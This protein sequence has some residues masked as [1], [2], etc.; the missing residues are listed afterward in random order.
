[1]PLASSIAIVPVPC[2]N[3]CR[4]A[5]V[6]VDVCVMTMGLVFGRQVTIRE[7]ES[8]ETEVVNIT[9]RR[10]EHARQIMQVLMEATTHR[11][12]G[13]TNINKHS[14]RSHMIMTINVEVCIL[15]IITNVSRWMIC[16]NS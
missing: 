12:H 8:G 3:I 1:M 6:A 2:S 15:V 10:I 13:V 9:S 7:T 14:S 5:P 11:A 16:Y 4:D